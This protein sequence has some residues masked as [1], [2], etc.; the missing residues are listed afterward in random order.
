M[1]INLTL[2]FVC[3]SIESQMTEAILDVGITEC[4][5]S[6]DAALSLATALSYQADHFVHC[7]EM[8]LRRLALLQAFLTANTQLDKAKP[9]KKNAV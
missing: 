1:I 2:Y 5:V 4:L 7:K 3:I 9:E 6:L 8:L